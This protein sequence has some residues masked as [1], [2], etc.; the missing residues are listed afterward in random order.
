MGLFSRKRDDEP[1]WFFGALGHGEEGT[2]AELL[3]LF[4]V[5]HVDLQ[6]VLLA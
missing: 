3:D 5:Q 1:Q 6:A 4:A 2:H